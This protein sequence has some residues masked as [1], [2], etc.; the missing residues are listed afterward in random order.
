M[1]GDAR[2][3]RAF[4][5]A[6]LVPPAVL[7][8]LYLD[9]DVLLA[10]LLRSFVTFVSMRVSNR[11]TVSNN[12]TAAQRYDATSGEGGKRAGDDGYFCTYRRRICR[13][14]DDSIRLVAVEPSGGLKLRS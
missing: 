7:F 4:P 12:V 11:D 1:S 3:A 10:R 14:R 8:I 5:S 6:L 13:P 9:R 2:N